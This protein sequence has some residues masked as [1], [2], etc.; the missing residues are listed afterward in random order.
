MNI[1][2]ALVGIVLSLKNTKFDSDVIFQSKR[3]L[4]DYIGVTYAG[5]NILKNSNKKIDY[6]FDCK[7]KTTSLLGYGKK[8]S[9]INSLF[10][11][12]FSSHVAELDDGMNSGIIHPGSPVIS[13]L[14]PFAEENSIVGLKLLNS[15]V[16][17]YE[18]TSLLANIIQPSHKLKGYHATGTCGMIG[19]AIAIATMLDYSEEE[20]KKT[21]SNAVISASGM[22]KVLEDNS[23]LKP[24]NVAKAALNAGVAA[25]MAK[26]GLN[27]PNDVFSGESGFLNIFSNKTNLDL[28]TNYNTNDLYINKIYVK[29]YSACRYCHPSIDA[30][31]MIRNDKKYSL[32]LVS[33][34]VVHTYELAVK[35]HDHTF[36]ENVSSAKMSI[37]FSIAVSLF[38]GNAG[39]LEYSDEYISNEEI[40]SL[41][42]KIKVFSS[43]EYTRSFPQKSTTSVEVVFLDGTRLLRTI[44]FPRG[45]PENPLTKEELEYKFSSLMRFSDI[46]E[47]RIS[48]LIN[49]IWDIE[50]NAKLLYGILN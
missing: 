50:K 32:S 41:M 42:K 18:V 6:V 10:I 29:P 9:L 1:T 33:E 12:G 3:C 5:A 13:S 4:L 11:N 26:S 22:L 30:S 15:I 27:V 20:I 34:I 49:C 24:Y 44:D 23:E 40:K 35:N 31:L 47:D 48:E 17:G 21:I 19:G 43:D 36:I 46:S 39:I 38:T 25:I 28:L 37:P 7:D 45:E 2:D 16:I 8:S 14:L